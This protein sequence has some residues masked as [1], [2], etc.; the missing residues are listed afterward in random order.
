MRHKFFRSVNAILGRV[1]GSNTS[2]P[3]LLSLIEAQCLPILTYACECV[4]WKKS[5]ATDMERAYSQVFFKIF[6]TYDVKVIAQC[7]YFLG[8]LPLEL[9]IIGRKLKFLNNVSFSASQTVRLLGRNDSEYLSLITKYSINSQSPENW[10][11]AV[12]KVFEDN[13]HSSL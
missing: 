1:G 8:L 7:Q 10:F 13:I 2:T 9:K 12:W 6:K 5:L 4:Q 3:V 11:G